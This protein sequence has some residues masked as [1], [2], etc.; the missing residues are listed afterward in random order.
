M[1]Q[2]DTHLEPQLG[3]LAVV[4]SIDEYA[5]CAGVAVKVA[6]HDNGADLAETCHHGLDVEHGGVQVT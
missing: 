1:A 5:V 6:V 4:T 3:V 2:S